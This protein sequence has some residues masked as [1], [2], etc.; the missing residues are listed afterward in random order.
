MKK[1][2]LGLTL[3]LA[4]GVSSCA[5]DDPVTTPTDNT[6]THYGT[7][8]KVG[9]DSARSYVRV[10]DKG[11]PVAIGIAIDSAA[12]NNIPDGHPM[13]GISFALP[14]PN[15]GNAKLP[16]KHITLDWNKNGHEPNHIY[17]VGHF[18]AH[19]YLIT[20][21]EKQAIRLDNPADTAKMYKDPAASDIPSDY[22]GYANIPGIGVIPIGGA[23][24][25]G[26]HF[27]DSTDMTNHGHQS[28]THVFIYGF[29]NGKMNFLE[30]MITHAFIDSKADVTANIK[31]PQTY[32]NSGNYWPTKYRIYYDNATHQHRIEMNT[33]VQR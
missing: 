16:Y 32:L 9:D 3:M 27:S 21:T 23:P 25:M 7:A 4:L 14:L 20:E 6:I 26:W 11:N 15:E 13:F 1:S 5:E 29:H 19:F 33:M 24:M 22:T 28:F 31:Q 8:V 17:G 30:P 18:D 12:M 2:L 10:D